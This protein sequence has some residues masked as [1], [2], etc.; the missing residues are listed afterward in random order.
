MSFLYLVKL[1]YSF[2]SLDSFLSLYP[3]CFQCHK[4][5]LRIPLM[6]FFFF[7][8]I[9]SSFFLQPLSLCMLGSGSYT[10]FHLLHI[11]ESLEWWQCQHSNN[12]LCLLYLHLVWFK[13]I[14]QVFKY[15]HYCFLC[16]T[17]FPFLIIHFHKCHMC[18]SL[19][20]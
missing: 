9:T 7:A 14:F 8:G 17:K 18:L 10:K 15:Y 12:Q 20:D 13:F 6:C 2:L 11:L 3:V 16:C 5:I 1:S 4:I 19:G